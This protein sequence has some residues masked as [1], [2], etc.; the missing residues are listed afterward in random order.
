MLTFYPSHNLAEKIR[1]KSSARDSVPPNQRS[2]GP[3]I[4][5]V[6]AVNSTEA[7]GQQSTVLIEEM[8]MPATIRPIFEEIIEFTR[9][10]RHIFKTDRLR[11]KNAHERV[12]EHDVNH[13][14]IYAA[15]GDD[16]SQG[17]ILPIKQTNSTTDAVD[18]QVQ[19][20][21]G[22]NNQ[23]STDN[24][25]ST[26]NFESIDTLFQTQTTFINTLFEQKDD[27]TQ[28]LP[29]PMWRLFSPI[30][31]LLESLLNLNP[32]RT[33]MSVHPLGGCKMAD[34][35][36]NGVTD[37]YGRVFDSSKENAVHNGLYV[38]DLSLIHI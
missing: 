27:N 36:G 35:M 19:I 3:T 12:D 30:G 17:Q 16:K 8:A 7:D 23:N 21:W 6:V 24:K 18:G 38:L 25:E 28:L 22:N 31:P 37:E 13:T 15:I 33:A 10:I 26:E 29:N 11:P 2:I 9:Y 5:G 14:A 34:T 4:G 1:P 20:L 32:T